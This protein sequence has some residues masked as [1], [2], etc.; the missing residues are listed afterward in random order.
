MNY[1]ITYDNITW[2]NDS[3]DVFKTYEQPVEQSVESYYLDYNTIIDINN[4]R[5][6]IYNLKK[7]LEDSKK[8]INKLEK[9]IFEFI[10]NPDKIKSIRK[11][12]PYGEEEW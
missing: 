1:T 12:D 5:S 4:M 7:E 2:T 3:T 11:I 10:D 8:I 9:L 6:E